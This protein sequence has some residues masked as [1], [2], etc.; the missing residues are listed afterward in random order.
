[1]PNPKNSRLRPGPPGQAPSPLPALGSLLLGTLL[2]AAAPGLGGCARLGPSTLETERGNYN[3]AV[4]RTNDEQ[5]LLNLVRLKYRDTPLFLEVTSVA[6]QY[7]LTGNANANATLESGAAGIFGL[8]AG[9]SMAEKPTVTYSPLQGDKFIRRVL[10]PV[11]LK[12]I[13][14]LYHSGW[15]VDRIF[16]LCFQRLNALKNAPGASGPTPSVAPDYED[17]QKAVRIVRLLQTK[18]AMDL[19]YAEPD[20]VPALVLEIAPEA[21]DWPETNALASLLGIAPGKNRYFLLSGPV[22]SQDQQIRMQ[23]RSLLGILFYLSQAVE[24]PPRDV[25][26]GRVTRTIYP[27]GDPFDWT[28]MTGDL[29]RIASSA[30]P[31]EHAAVQVRYRGTWFYIDDT[32]L[33]S[34]STFS[35]LAQLFSLQAGEVKG[36]GPVLTLPLGD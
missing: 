12:N 18:D 22:S 17:F 19:L 9:A 5:L 20:G 3:I 4:Q 16:R 7:T 21:V 31:V 11:P 8:G 32:H 25:E 35:L 29:L 2:A 24:A 34:K 6:S 23:P 15:S 1:M 30:Q 26:L 13:S 10:S 36:D 27:N 28:R 14:L 33:D